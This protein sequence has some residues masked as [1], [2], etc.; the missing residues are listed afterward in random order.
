MG[1]QRIRLSWFCTEFTLPPRHDCRRQTVSNQVHGCPRHIHQLIN[2]NNQED[3]LK[4]QTKRDKRPRENNL[5]GARN[6]SHSL[7]CE[8]ER[9]HD[10]DLLTKGKMYARCLCDKDGGDRQV[11]CRSIKVE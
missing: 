5:R 6:S 7:A 10:R 4:R 1:G 2:S 9:E 11:Q 8:H 3:S